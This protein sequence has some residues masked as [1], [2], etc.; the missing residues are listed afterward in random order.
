M[1]AFI[2]SPVIKTAAFLSIGFW[3]VA[4]AVP[5]NYL[6]V[7]L[8]AALVF[9]ALSV[10]LMYSPVVIQA[11]ADNKI[12]RVAQLCM[13][14]VVSWAM[15][16]AIRMLHIVYHR[17][18]DTPSWVFTN[19]LVDYF[20]F[21]VLCGGVLHLTAPDSVSGKVPAKS[22]CIV[23]LCMAGGVALTGVAHTEGFAMWVTFVK[24]ILEA[25]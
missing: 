17:A 24:H 12:D 3:F 7:F 5:G 15:I 20:A 23:S 9:V 6:A 21:L 18:D 14:V 11:I 8:S 25:I 22:W 16:G 13:G 4:L 1:K 2:V 10:C 19:N